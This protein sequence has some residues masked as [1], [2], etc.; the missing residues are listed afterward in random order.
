MFGDIT[1]VVTWGVPLAR[2]C[3]SACKRLCQFDRATYRQSDRIGHDAD[4]AY[5]RW[6]RW[7]ERSKALFGAP[8]HRNSSLHRCPNLGQLRR[9]CSIARD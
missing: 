4:D 2:P 3:R 1:F 7:N 8:R 9:C 6:S 5:L